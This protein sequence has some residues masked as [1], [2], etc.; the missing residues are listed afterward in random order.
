M[1]P[2]KLKTV[3][4]YVRTA[5][6]ELLRNP[7]ESFRE[8][9][10]DCPEMVIIPAGSFPMGSPDDE[11]GHSEDE[12]PVHRVTIAKPFAISK[13][14]VTFD[15]WDACVNVGGCPPASASGYGRGAFP[16]INISWA[17]ANQYAA[18]FAKMTNRK[19]RLPTEAEWEYAA[20][21]ETTTRYSFGDD[22][23]KLGEY[24]WYKG[25]SGGRPHVVGAAKLPNGF[26]L[27]N[28]HGSVWE[29][30]ED[31]YIEGYATAPSDGSAISTACAEDRRVARGGSY[32]NDP[33]ELRSARRGWYSSDR[34]TQILGF[35][36]A[37]SLGE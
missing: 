23:A 2:Y 33:K 3:E 26:G 25:N 17:D 15:D 18:W 27:Y 29:W 19:Y 21:A 37:R 20:R 9:A 10:R 7:H 31:C 16:V 1:L 4:P 22:E 5:S 36:L 6:L 12:S 34:R 24:A 35:R 13:Y 28:V 11:K 30:V 32:D 14:L 8:C